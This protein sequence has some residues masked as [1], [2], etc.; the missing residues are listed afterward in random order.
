MPEE[1]TEDNS[2][3]HERL[4]P[5]SIAEGNVCLYLGGFFEG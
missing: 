4:S 2:T 1:T 3:E 5:N